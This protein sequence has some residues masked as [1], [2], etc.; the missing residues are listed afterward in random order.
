MKPEA[1]VPSEAGLFRSAASHSSRDREGPGRA[2][3]LHRFSGRQ[4]TGQGPDVTVWESGAPSRPRGAFEKGSAWGSS[5]PQ[6]RPPESPSPSRTKQ[7]A[8]P[9][10]FLSVA[11]TVHFWCTHFSN[12][13]LMA[14]KEKGRTSHQPSAACAPVTGPTPAW[15][16]F[17]SPKEWSSSENLS[18]Q[19]HKGKNLYFTVV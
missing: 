11:T 19:C 4:P 17:P 1:Q 16:R 3:H 12:G 10:P 18:L 15:L 13:E 8:F 7:L 6:Q 9:K 14:R 5:R 2:L